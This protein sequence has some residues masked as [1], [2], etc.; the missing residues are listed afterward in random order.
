MT[1]SI[2]IVNFNAGGLL[3][4]SVRSVLA[5]SIPIEVIVVDNG[6][7]DGSIVR[8]R[9]SITD[10]RLNIIENFANLGFARASN[11]GIQPATGEYILL[12]NPDTI[13]QPDTLERLLPVF[14]QH[15]EAGIIGCMICNPDGSEQA[16]CRRRVP[17]PARSLVRMLH[18]D[19]P[20]PFLREKS[21]LLHKAPLPDT[22]IEMEALSG[23][24]MFVRRK[25]MDEVGLLDEKYF[26]H[27]EDLDWCMRFRSRGWRILFVPDVEIVHYKGSCS[28]SRPVR[29]E[30]HK[31]CGMVHFYQRFFRHQYPFWMLWLVYSGIWFRFS[32]R[33]IV[34]SVKRVFA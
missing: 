15:P 30:W 4:R 29:V 13:I 28:V 23:A 3:E 22:P 7:G 1:V 27:C 33:A 19:K 8:L 14:G 25:A 18:L 32:V 24:F 6:S 31:H 17:T 10:E 20:F 12:L 34:L 5:S 11:I 9:Q 26:L 16:G 21:V 2:I